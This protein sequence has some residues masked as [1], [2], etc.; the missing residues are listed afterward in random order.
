[1]TP[2]YGV[3]NYAGYWLRIVGPEP[4]SFVW[5]IKGRATRLQK[6]EAEKLANKFGYAVVELD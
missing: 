2:K 3:M 1:M 6:D 4:V 5:T